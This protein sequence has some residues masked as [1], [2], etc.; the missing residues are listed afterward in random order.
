MLAKLKNF[1]SQFGP[2]LITASAAIGTSHFVQATR[3]GSYFG[4]ELLWL[5]ILVNI[6]KYPFIEFGARYVSAKNENLLFGYFRYSKIVF[7]LILFISLIFTTLSFAA[8]GFVCAGIIKVVF[9]LNI[10]INYI[11]GLLLLF[12]SI[13]ITVGRYNLL[14]NMMKIFIIALTITT[15]IAVVSTL[16]DFQSLPTEEI[17]YQD[18]A[19]SLQYLPFL[20]ALMGWMPGSIDLSVWHSLWLKA[21]NNEKNPLNFKQAINDFN[22][23]YFITIITAILFLLIGALM[24]HNSKI[25]VPE[26]S[27]EFA[28]LLIDLYSSSIGAWA[29]PIIGVAIMSAMISTCLAVVDSYPRLI[30]ESFVVLKNDLSLKKKRIIHSFLMV[31]YSFLAFLTVSFL[32]DN[33]TKLL[34]FATIIAFIT[35]PIYAIV[36]YKIITSDEIDKK[37]HPKLWLKILSFLGIIFLCGFLMLFF[38]AFFI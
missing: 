19:M 28:R 32:F 17:F 4:F 3:A 34:D 27:D 5:V 9:N 33:F 7:Y 11:V 16:N 36:N 14:D 23:G 6:L 1:T 10:K 15:F 38:L 24:I 26:K 21:R 20:I 25:V 13:L 30:T 35:A 2:G 8:N 12:C 18:S 22:V 31:L 29:S 37:F